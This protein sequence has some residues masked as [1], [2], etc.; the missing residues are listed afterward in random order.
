M[1]T[2]RE[3]L[4]REMRHVELRRRLVGADRLRRARLAVAIEAVTTRTSDTSAVRIDPAPS[5]HAVS[6]IRGEHATSRLT[7][8]MR[9]ASHRAGDLHLFRGGQAGR[10][11]RVVIMTIMAGMR[12]SPKATTEEVMAIIVRPT[13]LSFV[14]KRDRLPRTIVARQD[15]AR[16]T[17]TTATRS[18][19][20]TVDA[21]SIPRHSQHLTCRAALRDVETQLNERWNISFRLEPM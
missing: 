20:A 10:I 7:G 21:M 18:T 4:H 9:F 5:H 14:L 11:L 15:R 19:T 16:T 12:R 1:Q 2:S 6:T 13:V 3:V 17:A 8:M